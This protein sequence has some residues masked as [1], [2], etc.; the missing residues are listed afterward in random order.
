MQTMVKL[1]AVQG[2]MNSINEVAVLLNEEHVV[3]MQLRAFWEKAYAMAVGQSTGALKVFRLALVATGIGALIVGLGLLISNW[4]AVTGAVGRAIKWFKGLGPVFQAAM[5]VL[6]PFI[7]MID[8]VIAGL[9]MIGVLETEEDKKKSAMAAKSMARIDKQ[10]EKERELKKARQQAH[11]NEQKN[12]DREIALAD[13]MGQSTLKLRQQKI[14]ASID[15]QKEQIK[16]YENNIKA[17]DILMKNNKF[18]SG[19]Y[20]EQRAEAKENLNKM[21]EDVK[22]QE[23]DKKIN[24]INANK[25][26]ADRAKEAAQEELEMRRSIE[27]KILEER[28]QLMADLEAAETKY[29]DSLLSARDLELQSVGDYYF[30]L[31]TRAEKAGQDTSILKLAQAN[32]EKEITDKFNKQDLATA[33]E[34]YKKQQDALRQYQEF[35]LT[36]SELAVVDFDNTQKEQKKI[37]EKNLADGFITQEQYDAALIGMAEARAKKMKELGDKEVEDKKAIGQKKFEEDTKALTAGLEA[38][39]QALDSFSAINDA[40]NQ[41]QDNKL[42][43][44][45]AQTDAQLTELDKQKNAEL[46][47]ANLTAAQKQAIEDKYAMAK[48]NVQKK[49]FEAEDKIKREQF[50]RD[51]ALKLASIA[52]STAQAVMQSIATGGG[53]PIGIPFGIA[54]GIVGAAQLAAVMSTKYEGGSA[55]TMP[56]VGGAATSTASATQIG[57]AGTTNAQ[58]TSLADYLPG[59]SNGPAVSQVVVLESDITG[60]QQKVQTQQSLSTY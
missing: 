43:A 8:L 38:A 26:A 50:K 24:Q 11:D 47:N 10:M 45:Q 5:L 42:K 32:A 1:Q 29:N 3:G 2:V 48:Y 27:K 20:K 23:T 59:G 14:Q 21:T 46:N 56:E 52:I 60:T 13:A 28:N 36:E 55:P 34:K 16:E 22:D 57:G 31:I 40:M 54:A 51:K 39:Q 35:V 25:E 30:D 18:L 4:D 15:Y 53:I 19:V 33:E 49:Q 58:T 17:L 44:M 6:Q 41:V 12:F 9:Q 37:L 7:F